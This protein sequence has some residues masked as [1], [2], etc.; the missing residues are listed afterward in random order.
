[1][2]AVDEDAAFTRTVLIAQIGRSPNNTVRV[3]TTR[4]KA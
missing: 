2:A 4:L 3:T 1:M